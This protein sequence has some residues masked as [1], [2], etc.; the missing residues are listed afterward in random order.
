M[1]PVA[2]LAYAPNINWLLAD[3]PSGERPRA[4]AQAGFEAIE[5]GFPSTVDLEAIDEARKAYG[6][7]VVLF[8]Q[9]VPLWDRQNRGYLSDAKRRDEFQRTLDEA[10]TLAGRL[11]AKKIML[12]AGVELPGID[13]RVQRDWVIENLQAAAP[14]AAQAGVLLTIEVLNPADNP[15]YW[16]TS[17]H[18]AVDIVRHVDHPHVRVQFDT[19]HLHL[20]EGEV[21]ET[22]RRYA[23]W[24]GHVQFGDAPGRVRPR[25]GEVDFSAVL[26]V[27]RT[28]GYEGFIGLEYIPADG[29]PEELDWV[30]AE[31]RSQSRPRR[32]S[33][34]VADTTLSEE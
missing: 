21:P 29:G 12:P 6:L 16:L 28:A 26:Q 34:A 27:L 5:F 14:L 11:Q 7:E 9:E 24:L 4:V 22:F 8:N 33:P 3:L 13:R 25:T 18:E 23:A 32:E 30:S 2:G 1:S 31:M 10:L 20:V 15:G 19:Y 17:S